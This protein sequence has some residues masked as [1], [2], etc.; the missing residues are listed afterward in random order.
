MADNS[1]APLD[2]RVLPPTAPSTA[3]RRSK[4]KLNALTGLRF[5]AAVHVVLFHF[6]GPLRAS[7]PGWAQNLIATGY[8]SV[9]LFFMLSGF[10][11]AY[12]HPAVGTASGAK[13]EFWVARFA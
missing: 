1:T 7:W 12:T 13:R 6:T 5:I 8:V 11:L 4:T 10:I 2:H 9:G 3:G